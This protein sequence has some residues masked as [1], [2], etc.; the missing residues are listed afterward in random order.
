M[1]KY[2]VI[3]KF[4]NELFSQMVEHVRMISLVEVEFVYKSGDIIK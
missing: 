1:K 3:K 4:D 2:K